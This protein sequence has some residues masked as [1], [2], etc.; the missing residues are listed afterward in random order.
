MLVELVRFNTLD[1]PCTAG[2]RSD[3]LCPSTLK[4]LG[5]TYPVR[6]THHL[7]IQTQKS[8]SAGMESGG[9]QEY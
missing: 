8:P 2:A 4:E 5:G 7:E 6:H 9:Y 3:G 1:A